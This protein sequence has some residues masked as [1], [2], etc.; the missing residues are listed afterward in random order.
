MSRCRAAAGWAV[1]SGRLS[2]D[3]TKVKA[4]GICA[5]EEDQRTGHVLS[6]HSGQIKLSMGF[7]KVLLRGLDKMQGEWNLV[8]LTHNLLKLFRSGALT[9]S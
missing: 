2:L 6:Q 7:R 1:V 3:G 4:N 5:T 9:T 8:C